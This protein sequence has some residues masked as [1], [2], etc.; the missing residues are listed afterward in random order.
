MRNKL[1]LIALIIFSLTIKAQSLEETLSKLSSTAGKAYV[2]PVISAFGSNL[3]SGWVS[4]LPQ[5]T[6]FGFHIDIKVVAMGSLFSDENK[7]F[8]TSGKFFFTPAQADQILQSSG[9]SIT[10]PLYNTIKNDLTKTE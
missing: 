2:A 4:A 10:N 9:V 3:N 5:P 1:I 7:T 6:K 8:A